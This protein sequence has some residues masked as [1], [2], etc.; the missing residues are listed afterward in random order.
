MRPPCLRSILWDAAPGLPV[1]YRQ[2]PNPLSSCPSK[3]HCT[4]GSP[5]LRQAGSSFQ[6]GM[7]VHK[8]NPSTQEVEAGRVQVQSHPRLNSEFQ[9]EAC[10][11]Y[12]RPCLQK[13]EG[14]VQLERWLSPLQHLLLLQKAQVWFPAPTW[15]SSQTFVTAAS[16][17]L[18]PLGLHWHLHS[19][20]YVR[21]IKNKLKKKKQ[22][23]NKK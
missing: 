18:L 2:R 10:L 5:G 23:K 20:T 19:H 7:T 22:P 3:T 14:R 15:R 13:Q 1:S 21:I 9:F 4:Q 16:W 17:D 8:C 11:A 6:P 12:V